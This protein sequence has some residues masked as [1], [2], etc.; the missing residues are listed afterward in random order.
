MF[1]LVWQG[2]TIEEDIKTRKEAEY[3]QGEYAMAYKGSVQIKKQKG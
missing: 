1:K 2:E 3:L